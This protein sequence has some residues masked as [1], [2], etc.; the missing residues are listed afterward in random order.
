MTKVVL[1]ED[2][3]LV[4]TQL[5]NVLNEVAPEMEILSVLDSVEA[6]KLWFQ[7]HAMPD[8]ILSDIQLSD[9]VSFEIFQELEVSCPI[10]FTTAYNEFAIRAFK[11]NSIDYLLKPIRHE[12]LARAIDKFKRLHTMN[13]QELIK[14]Q[15][16]HL[17]K[18]LKQGKKYKV[19]F[20][21]HQGQS[22]VSVP[23]EQTAGFIKDEL[24]FLL[25]KDGKKSI[26]DYHTLDELEE[27]LD[28]EQF[29]RA[30][31]QF[32]IHLSAVMDY[33]SH[34]TGKLY[35]HLEGHPTTEII[36]SR[37][38]AASFKKWFEG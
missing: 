19:R 36:V 2:E 26:T 37:E 22:I 33:K 17:F 35:V 15:F 20:T 32:I 3:K 10:I 27:L 38:K 18:D 21:A 16:E 7:Q 9:G 6:G 8:L 24:I 23:A 1:I 14:H 28:P 5:K 4:A 12:D 29:Y 25:S 34:Y 31:R 11:L 30:N 13:S